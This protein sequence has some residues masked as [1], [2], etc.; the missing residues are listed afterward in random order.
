MEARL[1]CTLFPG[2]FS[3]ELAVVIRSL[4][5]RQYSLFAQISDCECV[6][7]PMGNR[8][9]EGFIR[10]SVLQCERGSCVIRLPYTTLENGQ[11]I[12]VA[13]NQLDKTPSETPSEI[14]HDPVE[15]G[16]VRCS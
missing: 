2:Q 16:N 13:A 10:V 15:S 14:A 11:Y 4:S 1:R 8:P 12:T 3:S 9:V 7:L 5:G 6:H